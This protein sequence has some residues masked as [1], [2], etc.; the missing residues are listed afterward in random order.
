MSFAPPSPNPADDAISLHFVLPQ[1]GRVRLM[2]FDGLGRIRAVLLD[3]EVS[4]G[5]HDQT[6]MLRDDSGRRL[7]AGFYHVRL[8]AGGRVITRGFAAVR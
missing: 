1:A 8:E 7:A 6:F 5:P 3:D 2:L 4:A